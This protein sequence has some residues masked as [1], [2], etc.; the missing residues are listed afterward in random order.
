[1]K[2]YLIPLILVVILVVIFVSRDLTKHETLQ[3]GAVFP[4]TGGLASIGEDLKNGVDLA[5][6]ETGLSVIIEDGQADP[7]K[8]LT[9]GQYLTD[10]DNVPIILTAFRGA[11]LSL[12]SNLKNKNVVIFATTATTEGKVTSTSSDKFF[13]VGGEMLSAGRVPGQYAANNNLCKRVSLI[14]EQSDT[15]KDKLAGFTDGIGIGKIVMTEFFQPSET[16]FKSLITKMKAS[17]SDC[18]FVEIRSNS[19]PTLLTQMEQQS[20]RPKIFANSYSVTPQGVKDSP[21]SEAGN[22]IFSS[23]AFNLDSQKTQDFISAYRTAYSEEPTDWAAIGYELVQ[24]VNQPLKE[25]G[26]NVDCIKSKL[27]SIQNYDSAVGK[28]S[29][30]INHEIQLKDYNLYKIVSGAFVKI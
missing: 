22:V 30:D 23:T 28:L 6:K 17:N 20:F 21:A 4:M 13:V 5:N 16:D 29:V 26:K 8:S 15:G 9:A 3:F 14:S 19:F 7:Q 25:C 2:K 10:V 18:M 1:M 27:S 24:M 12:A 11:S